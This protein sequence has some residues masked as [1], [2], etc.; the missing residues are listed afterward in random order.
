[1][2]KLFA[3]LLAVTAMGTAVHADVVDIDVTV[4]SY[5]YL[6]VNDD[7][8]VGFYELTGQSAFIQF[9]SDSMTSGNALDGITTGSST[10][11]FTELFPPASFSDYLTFAYFGRVNTYDVDNNLVDTSLV[12]AFQPG[13]GVGEMVENYFSYTEADLVAAMA[14]NDSPE[15]LSMLN[16][17]IPSQPLVQGDIAVPPIGQP[18]QTLNLVA[19][20]GGVNGDQGVAIGTLDMTVTPE[21]ASLALLA[22]A[23][24]LLCQRRRAA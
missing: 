19:F 24:V 3:A 13:Y 15:F 1:M 8:Q 5:N 20:I 7:P 6:D 22:T 16:S 4:D 14:T 17:Q 23:G 21:P 18:G 12:I 2:R 11:S 9:R 10:V